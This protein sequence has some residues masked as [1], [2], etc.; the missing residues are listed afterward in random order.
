MMPPAMVGEL[1]PPV[2]EVHVQPFCIEFPG[3]GLAAEVM[4]TWTISPAFGQTT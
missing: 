4:W 3:P 1:A 2:G